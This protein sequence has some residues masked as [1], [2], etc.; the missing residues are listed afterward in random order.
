MGYYYNWKPYVPVARR[1]R[2]AAQRTK[3]LAKQ[4]VKIEP[5]VIEGTKIAKTFW[6]KAWCD[7]LESLR[8]FENRLPRGRT[9]VRN[10][11][12]CHLAIQ[13]GLVTALVSGS[14]LYNVRV[15]IDP[16]GKTKWNTLKQILSGQI[17]SLLELLQ[18]RISDRVMQVVTDRNEGLFPLAR[19][20]HLDCDCPDYA[21]M[22]KHVAA[23]LYGVG[24]RLDT[25]PEL[26][27]LLRGVDHLDLITAP[28][29]QAVVSATKRGG[30]RQVATSQLADVFGIELDTDEAESQTASDVSST[31]AVPRSA[32][33]TK[34]VKKSKI[35]P[36]KQ[37][38]IDR[39]K[40]LAAEKAA[41]KEQKKASPAKTG[42]QKTAASG[43]G[44]VKK[45]TARK[46]S[47]GTTVKQPAAK[48]KAK[49]VKKSVPKESP[50]VPG[51]RSAA[52]KKS[53]PK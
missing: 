41:K 49:A 19:E 47:S 36:Q 9:Y 21:T 30:R 33:K 4:G 26:L 42:G 14:D 45:V 3:V 15:K 8:D 51:G 7:Q 12:V 34:P 31:P 46:S 40:A 2:Q 38:M 16:L 10:G 37:R 52:K 13:T 43:S 25:Q 29:E 32:G 50:K 1:R 17:G 20:I 27:F 39:L 6:G 48:K 18:G 53:R 22:C 44:K 5:V 35:S 28:T 23:V 24:A 11:S